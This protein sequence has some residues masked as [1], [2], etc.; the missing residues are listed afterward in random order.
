LLVL[1]TNLLMAREPVYGVG[2]WAVFYQHCAYNNSSAS[3][4]WILT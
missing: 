1:F 2:E 3:N 4:S